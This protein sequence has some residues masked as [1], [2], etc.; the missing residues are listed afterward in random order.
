MKR[1]IEGDL[2]RVP[3]IQ[4]LPVLSVDLPRE[5]LAF[6]ERV[7]EMFVVPTWSPASSE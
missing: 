5:H 6:I 3:I 2:P 1:E 4:E 7:P